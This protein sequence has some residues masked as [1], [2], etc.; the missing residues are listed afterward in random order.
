MSDRVLLVGASGELGSRIANS[1]LKRGIPLRAMTRSAERLN[2]LAAS[3]AEVVEADMM[4]PNS[5]DAV[6]NV[7][8]VVTTAN[9][10]TGRG[11]NAPEK[12]DLI[13][14]RNLVDAARKAGVDHY[15][16]V[17]AKVPDEFRRIDYFRIKAESE[18]Y[19][20]NSELRH[21]ILRPTAF[22]E[23]WG[24]ILGDSI[25]D[26]GIAPVFGPGLQ[27]SNYIAID[28]VAQVI[29]LLVAEVPDSD[30]VIEIGGPDN[31][32]A[33]EL[34]DI[35]AKAIQRTPKR[36]SVPLPLLW[37]ISRIAGL[38]NPV[39]GRKMKT[40]Y[41]SAKAPE[42]FDFSSVKNRFPIAWTSIET[43]ATRNYGTDA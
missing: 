18:A 31:V 24:Q 22:L 28:D 26:K 6:M 33:H 39:N 27:K 41:A 36:K 13:G 19:L 42:T 21:T 15:L 29:A 43:W 38:F 12:T 17:S 32:T 20:G 25:R 35:L 2:H 5:L 11:R 34:I 14:N 23:T 10:F 40:A 1:F 37:I 8:Q 4:D 3:G 16:M 7:R 9:S 30:R